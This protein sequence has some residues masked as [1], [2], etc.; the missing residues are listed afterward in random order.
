MSEAAAND[1]ARTWTKWLLPVIPLI[2]AVVGFIV[3]IGRDGDP[4]SVDGPPTVDLDAVSTE[5]LESILATSRDDPAFADEIPGVLLVLAERYFGDGDYEQAF[6]AYAEIL[7]NP[8]A[9]RPQFAIA[10]SRV[11]WIGWLSTGDTAAALASVDEALALAP[12][13][14]ETYYIKGQILW[15]G[16]GD[17]TSAVELFTTVLGAPDLPEEVRTQ[18]TE[19]LQAAEAGEDCR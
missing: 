1:G 4:A 9:R 2:V 3:I 11:A 7:D 16:A 12:D 5:R 8:R 18:V 17:K 19:D 14:S 13:N 15:C 6:A 10:L